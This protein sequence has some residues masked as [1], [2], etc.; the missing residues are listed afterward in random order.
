MGKPALSL[1]H[2][3]T[4]LDETV[5]RLDRVERALK[6]LLDELEFRQILGGVVIKELEKTIEGD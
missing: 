4:E 1:K 2:M 6:L 5:A 3:K